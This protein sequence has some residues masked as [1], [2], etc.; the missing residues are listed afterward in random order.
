[1]EGMLGVVEDSVCG[2]I[3]E[4]TGMLMVDMW[5]GNG[6]WRDMLEH[7]YV[8]IN[9]AFKQRCYDGGVMETMEG[10]EG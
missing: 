5:K 2:T 4:D 10:G 8:E 3:V 1:M 7:E 9:V 6:K